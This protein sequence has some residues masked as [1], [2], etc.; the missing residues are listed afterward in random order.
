MADS[1]T[2]QRAYTAT[3]RHF[4]ETGRAPHYIELARALD[5]S[6]DAARAAQRGAAEAGPATWF[7]P[8]TDYVASWAPFSNVP[9]QHLISVDGEQRWYGQ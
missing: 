3:V 1:G 6:S 7:V 2:I 4:M 8:E 9:T 5:L